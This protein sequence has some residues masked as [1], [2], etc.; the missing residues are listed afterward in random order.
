M[1]R[2]TLTGLLG[3]LA[4]VGACTAWGLDN[5]LTR[6]VSLADPPQVVELKGLIAGPFNVALAL[7]MG[8]ALPTAGPIAAAGLVGVL[9]LW[10][11]LSALRIGVAPSGYGTHGCVFLNGAVLWRS[12]GRRAARRASYRRTNGCR[13]PNGYRRLASCDRTARA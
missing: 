12:H 7:W 10:A 5:N 3:P 13:Q 9:G 8:D 4:I 1:G 6:K 2:P 11:Q